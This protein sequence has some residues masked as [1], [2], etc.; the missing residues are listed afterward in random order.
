MVIDES[1]NLSPPRQIRVR[2]IPTD[3]LEPN[4]HNP[5]RLFDP[6]P[7]DVLENS[8]RKVGIL[9]PLTVY[10]DS[11]TKKFVIL[12]GQR[13]WICAQKIGLEEVP[14]NEVEEPNEV[15]N[16]VTMFQ[17]HKFREDWELMPTALKLEILIDKLDER[18]DKALAELTG[19]DVA[20]V[21]RCKKLLTFPKKYQDMML[22]T[23]PEDRIKADFF[24]ELYAVLT[25][26]AMRE[27][28]WAHRDRVTS[29]MLEKYKNK[30]SGLKSVTDFRKIKQHFVAARKTEKINV[31]SH[32]FKE[33]LESD[34][35]PIE[36]LEVAGAE[37][38]TRA[39]KIQRNIQKLSTD[40]NNLEPQDFIGEE[41]LWLELEELL[42]LIRKKLHQ[43]DRRVE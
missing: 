18:R 23:R 7:L 19:L 22:F 34:D 13:R 40:L 5:R 17:I 20:V 1:E 36:H 14:V 38:R 30:R 25:D 10:Q 11:K 4:P 16:I 3:E 15:Q 9:V 37:I 41:S 21:S 28:K 29:I 31:L 35:L 8:I 6:Q 12:D 2:K 39:E 33:F 27:M 42:H 24:I 43:A 32:V 26:R